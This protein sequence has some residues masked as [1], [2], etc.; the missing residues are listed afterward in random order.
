[1]HISLS[2]H[3][4]DHLRQELEKLF[5]HVPLPLTMTGHSIFSMYQYRY[6]GPPREIRGPGA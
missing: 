3:S 6:S 1:M 2:H 5:L 4:I